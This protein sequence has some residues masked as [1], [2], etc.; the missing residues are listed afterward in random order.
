MKQYNC[1]NCGA[2]IKHTYNHK[3]EYCGSIVDFNEPIEDVVKVDPYNLTDLQLKSIERE[4]Y[5]LDYIFIFTGYVIEKPKFYDIEKNYYEVRSISN[6]KK[7]YW[8]L[9][10]SDIDIKEYGTNAII[11]RVHTSGLCGSE[12]ENVLNQIRREFKY[13]L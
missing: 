7:V 1:K 4:P 13:N 2:N 11:F 10:I 9:R 8:G 5:T 3:C 12:M 6:P